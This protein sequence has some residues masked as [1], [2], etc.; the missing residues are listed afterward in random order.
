M[1]ADGT[2]RQQLSPERSQDCCPS[3]SPDGR[4]IVFLSNRSGPRQAWRMEIDG[5]NP[6]QLTNG[7]EDVDLPGFGPGGETVIFKL[8]TNRLAQVS[9]N[10]GP[11]KL[12][13]NDP[14]EMW[15]VSPNGKLLASLAEDREHYRWRIVVRSVEKDDAISY[16]DFTPY[17]TLH[18]TPDG[19]G[20]AYAEEGGNHSTIMVQ[21]LA[22]GAAK[23]LLDFTSGAISGFAWSR[24]GRLLALV[25]GTVTSHVVLISQ[26]R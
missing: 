24:D 16:F 5:R 3:V 6:Q 11:T 23:P 4:Y 18:W 19:S 20:L 9:I 1:D 21:P 10:G 2:R 8:H 13:T 17:K 15:E 25:G 26:R 12:L 22:G 14:T 7:N